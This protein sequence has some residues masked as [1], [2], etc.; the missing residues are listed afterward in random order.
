MNEPILPNASPQALRGTISLI[1]ISLGCAVVLFL[2]DEYRWLSHSTRGFIFAIMIGLLSGAAAP[3]SRVSLKYAMLSSAVTTCA[4]GLLLLYAV[5][6]SL[7]DGSSV[8]YDWSTLGCV[9]LAAVFFL[10][11]K[12][13]FN[14][15]RDEQKYGYFYRYS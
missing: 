4:P 15:F 9:A 13:L 5:W 14:A 6:R 2:S 1:L 12:A 10:I 11:A 3:L 8:W 7:R